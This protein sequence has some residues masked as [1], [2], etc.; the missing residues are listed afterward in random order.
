MA[1]TASKRVILLRHMLKTQQEVSSNAPQSS[2]VPYYSVRVMRY[3]LSAYTRKSGSI[4]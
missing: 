2:S 4:A 3:S 1:C